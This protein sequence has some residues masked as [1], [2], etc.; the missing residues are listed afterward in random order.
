MAGH[1]SSPTALDRTAYLEQG[2]VLLD[3]LYRLLQEVLQQWGRWLQGSAA[4]APPP[5]YFCGSHRAGLREG[6]CSLQGACVPQSLAGGP[7]AQG[8]YMRTHR[9]T[10]PG[11]LPAL[12]G[13]PASLPNTRETGLVGEQGWR[14]DPACFSNLGGQ[15]SWEGEAEPGQGQGR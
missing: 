8:A 15:G 7:G 1:R 2:L 13:W 11:G 6:E 3:P 4:A 14:G 5:V 12:R 9:P 10:S